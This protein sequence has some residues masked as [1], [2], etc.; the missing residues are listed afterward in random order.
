MGCN[1]TGD[2]RSEGSHVGERDS[3]S[4]FFIVGGMGKDFVQT[5]KRHVCHRTSMAIFVCVCVF[6]CSNTQ[7]GGEKSKIQLTISKWSFL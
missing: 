5:Q 4:D 3:K 7:F 1:H 2:K 6:V